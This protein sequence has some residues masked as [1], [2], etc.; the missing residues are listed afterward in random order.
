MRSKILTNYFNQLFVNQELDE[1]FLIYH[2]IIYF[3][4]SERIKILNIKELDKY[5][6]LNIPLRNEL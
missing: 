3:Y 4:S 1:H 6:A 2:S 5:P